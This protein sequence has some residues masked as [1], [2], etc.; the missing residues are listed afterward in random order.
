MGMGEMTRICEKSLETAL[1]RPWT[2]TNA[3]AADCG[4]PARGSRT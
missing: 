1:D 3:Y 2:T 4:R